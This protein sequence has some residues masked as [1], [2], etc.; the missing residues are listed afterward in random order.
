MAELVLSAAGAMIGWGMFE[1]A[2]AA[3]IG[4]IAGSLLASSLRPK[5][6]VEAQKLTDLRVTGSQYGDIIPWIYGTLR[7]SGQ[8]WWASDK[9]A[10]RH[11]ES[12]GGKGGGGGV[13]QVWYTYDVDLLLG[14]CDVECLSLNRVWLNGK[15]VFTNV[16]N[17]ASNSASLDTPEWSRLTLYNGAS[18]QLPDPTYETAV[19]SANAPAYRGRTYVFIEGLHLG[20][21]GQIPNLTFEINTA[22]ELDITTLPLDQTGSLS[23]MGTVNG[24]YYVSGDYL[25][26]S[27]GSPDPGL[28]I[29][30]ISD[31]DNPT[32]KSYTVGSGPDGV[33]VKGNY[34]YTMWS[35]SPNSYLYVWDIS[36]PSSPSYVTSLSIAPLTETLRLNGN[37][38]YTTGNNGLTILTIDISTPTA[39]VLVDTF[40]PADNAWNMRNID[41]IN[42]LYLATV[43]TIE[44][45]VSSGTVWNRLRILSLSNPADPTEV[46]TLNLDN[47]D[48]AHWFI[49]TGKNHGDYLHLLNVYGNLATPYPSEI[50]TVSIANPVGPYVASTYS[51]TEVDPEVRMHGIAYNN[52]LLYLSGWKMVSPYGGKL[53]VLDVTLPSSPIIKQ[54]KDVAEWCWHS[55]YAKD[56][57]ITFDY[58]NYVMLVYSPYQETY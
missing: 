43:C 5:Q 38:I 23:G 22:P 2:L 36:N 14:L 55:Q 4:W 42:G 53:A 8:V 48:N 1:T 56:R 44:D 58:D 3:R 51:L 37:Y 25:Y 28:R 54:V 32:I 40:T 49:S 27:S 12:Y 45:P 15:L 50:V 21:S 24:S 7:L 9:R 52:G 26:T 20:T 35:S 33:V 6:K 13:T 34:A 57:Y 18:D 39:P 10:I 41:I 31:V 30:D 17:A 46:T 16:G 47:I 29:I 19:G 11:E